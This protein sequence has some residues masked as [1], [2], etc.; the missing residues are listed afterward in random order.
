MCDWIVCGSD[1]GYENGSEVPHASYESRGRHVLA[2]AF[3]N[4]RHPSFALSKLE[5]PHPTHHL[6]RPDAPTTCVCATVG[7]RD[8]YTHFPQYVQ[9]DAGSGHTA[10]H[11]DSVSRMHPMAPTQTTTRKM[12]PSPQILPR[13]QFATFD[14]VLSRIDEVKEGLATIEVI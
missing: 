2:Q 7:E 5:T 9:S 8:T 12:G 3:A 13:S 4:V 10:P 1:F 6:L 11:V 14:D